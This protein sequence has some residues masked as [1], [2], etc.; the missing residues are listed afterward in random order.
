MTATEQA[1][2]DAI[3]GGWGS[4]IGKEWRVSAGY[5][6]HLQPSWGENI[7]ERVTA[8]STALID[9]T[10]WQAVGKTKGWESYE[11]SLVKDEDWVN[12]RQKMLDFID[13]LADGKSIKEALA[14]IS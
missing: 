11:D 10:F 5:I 13:H 7:W 6:E 12:W 4:H 1:I 3:D 14:A 9:P 2:K 8:V